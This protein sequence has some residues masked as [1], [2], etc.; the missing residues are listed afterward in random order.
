VEYAEIPVLVECS[1][2][3][4][5]TGFAGALP[6]Y[7]AMPCFQSDLVALVKRRIAL[8]SGEPKTRGIL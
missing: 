2:I 4:T 6:R 8:E 5:E 3:S 7:R 1:G